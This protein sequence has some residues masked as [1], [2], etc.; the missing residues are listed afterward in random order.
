L[1]GGHIETSANYSYTADQR[2][3][4]EPYAIQPAYSLI[5]AR[6]GWISPEG[7]F[8]VSLWGKNLADKVWVAHVY[9]IAAEVFGVYGEPRTY[10]ATF[11]WRLKP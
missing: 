9:T 5:D 4:L 1:Y 7:H 11:S 2:G 3:E 10:G 8:E 6:L